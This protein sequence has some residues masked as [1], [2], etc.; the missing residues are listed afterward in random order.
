MKRATA[1]M[2]AALVLTAGTGASAQN[3]TEQAEDKLRSAVMTSSLEAER[4]QRTQPTRGRSLTRTWSGIALAA[5]GTATALMGRSCRTMGSLP[6]DSVQPFHD[7]TITTSMTD[8]YA[9]SDDGDCRINFQIHVSVTDHVPD[10][11]G[12]MDHHESYLYNDLHRYARQGLPEQPRRNRTGDPEP[13]PEAAVHRHR[14][15]QSRRAS[16]W[17][18][19]SPTSPSA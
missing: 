10:P 19:S 18:P 14:H 15:A 3:I 4:Q 5:A 1:W 9:Y 12:S 17:Q 6:R 16:P 8:L 11:K 2:T 7:V 13:G